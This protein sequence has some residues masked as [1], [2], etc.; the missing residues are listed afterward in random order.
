MRT[1]PSGLVV[2]AASVFVLAASAVLSARQQVP[3]EADLTSVDFLAVGPDGRIIKDLTIGQVSLKVDGSERQIESL[4]YVELGDSVPLDRGGGVIPKP[5]AP[6]FASNR[7][8]DAGRV[9]MIVINDESI[10]PGKERPAREAAARFLGALSTRDRVALLTLPRGS[11]NVD[12]TRDHEQVRSALSRITGHAPQTAGTA[13]PS[14]PRAAGATAS[15]LSTSDRACSSRL[16]LNALAGALESIADIEGPKAVVFISSGLTPPTRDAPLTGP[17]GP[18]EIKSEDYEAVGAAACAARAYFYVIQPSDLIS[19]PAETVFSDMT[20]SRFAGTDDATAGLQN[21]VGVT[22][23]EIFKLSS[24][25]D[26][27]FSRVAAES[28][29]YYMAEFQATSDERNGQP[30]RVEIRVAVPDVKLR[31][32]SQLVIAKADAR[33]DP[34]FLSPEDML[35]GTRRFRTLPLRAMAFASMLKGSDLKV[36]AI[37]EPMDPSV[38]IASAAMGLIDSRGRMSKQWTADKSDLES[39]MLISAFPVPPGNYRL[40]VA[41]ID[42][43]GRHGTV[44]YPFTAELATA[45][46]LKLSAIALGVSRDGSFQP[47]MIFGDE[48]AAVAYLELYGRSPAPVIRLELAETEEGPALVDAPARL[49]ETDDPERRIAV[50]ALPIGGLLPGDYLVRVV[51]TNDGRPIGRATRTLRKVIAGKE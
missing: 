51:I 30:H 42:A 14:T 37:A 13:L 36:V 39:G 1:R 5:L 43:A 25:A 9:V 47:K 27:V 49:V 46:T 4:Q 7:L 6:P 19:D 44:E 28:S 22:A 32:G 18:C 17:P 41:A 12:L 8:A 50:G 29:G 35:R 10:R 16:T 48:P 33:K 23:G 40:R 34:K 38:R 24:S 26:P 3:A 21:L 15:Q 20:A 31:Y 11:V 2:W 45:G